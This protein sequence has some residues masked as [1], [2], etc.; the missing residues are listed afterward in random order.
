[1]PVSLRNH[2]MLGA[3]LKNKHFHCQIGPEKGVMHLAVAAIVNAL[4]DLWARLEN[5]PLWRLLADMEPEVSTRHISHDC[6]PY[7]LHKH[8]HTQSD[9]Q[10]A[11]R[12]HV[13]A[14]IFCIRIR[15]VAV[16]QTPIR[17]GDNLFVHTF[18]CGRDSRTHAILLCCVNCGLKN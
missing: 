14:G 8:T 17:C 13:F 10:A 5:K 9:I 15:D 6:S 4:W 2:S 3:R 16:K 7:H 12:S 11:G 1:M 18:K